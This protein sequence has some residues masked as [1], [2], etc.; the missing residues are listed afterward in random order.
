METLIDNDILV[1]LNK[2]ADA[3]CDYDIGDWWNANDLAIEQ[4]EARDSELAKARAEIKRLHSAL[5]SEIQRLRLAL[6]DRG[7]P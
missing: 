6:D 2:M 7:S 5:F 4:I 3:R 1:L